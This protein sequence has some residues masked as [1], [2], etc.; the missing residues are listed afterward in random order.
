MSGIFQV[1]EAVSL[2]LHGMGILALAG[3][4]MRVREMAEAVE[5]SEAHMA[6]VFQ[7][8]VRAGL[9][10]SVRGPAGGFELLKKPSE[11]S[12]YAVYRAIEGDLRPKS[13]VLGLSRCPF[14]ECMFGDFPDRVYEEFTD[15]LK[16]RSLGDLVGFEDETSGRGWIDGSQDNAQDNN[17]RQG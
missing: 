12:L 15:H 10:G 7:R 16:S 2:A 8:L 11:I 3:K 9:V 13:C 6:K 1:S 5:A 17:H 14:R 4:R